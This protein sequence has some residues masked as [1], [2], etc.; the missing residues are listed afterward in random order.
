MTTTVSPE[1]LAYLESLE[2]IHRKRLTHEYAYKQITLLV[3][4]TL[5]G[6]VTINQGGTI[7]TR[8]D[9]IVLLGS[10]VRNNGTAEYLAVS[11]GRL[12]TWSAEEL[13][14]QGILDDYEV[15]VGAN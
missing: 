7:T 15:T 10:A 5:K 13:E 6:T 14:E 8:D 11:N 4:L 12:T 9:K 2:E 3:P 1:R